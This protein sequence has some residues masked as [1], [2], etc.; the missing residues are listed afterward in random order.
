MRRWLPLLAGLGGVVTVVV[1]L[2]GSSGK[3]AEAAG[4]CDVSHA[5]ITQLEWDT[6]GA[7][8]GFRDAQFGDGDAFTLSG[9]YNRAA[10]WYA[11]HQLEAGPFGSHMD[12]YGRTWTQ[13]LI[14]CGL[15]ATTSGGTPLAQ[16]SGEAVYVIEGSGGPDVNGQA[17][18][19]GL[20]YAGSGLWK[21]PN[22][23]SLPTKCMGIGKFKTSTGVAWIVVVGQYYSAQACPEAVYGPEGEPSPTA[24][25][26]TP[27]P[28]P[29]PSPSPSPT[30]SATLTETP[31]A[32]PTPDPAFQSRAIG[33][34]RD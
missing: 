16:G 6:F 3:D 31:T 23:G 7:V 20:D 14:D 26:T 18:V 24:T 10:A 8:K 2:V 30:A 25:A 19:D 22:S 27:A 21:P 4:G 33:L 5:G 1:V 34:V 11:Q 32:S 15:T 9:P 29:S 13:R 12:A 17:A 28:S